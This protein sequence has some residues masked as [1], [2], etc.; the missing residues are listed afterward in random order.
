VIEIDELESYDNEERQRDA[1]DEETKK[2]K[3]RL[4]GP[5]GKIHNIVVNIRGST[6]RAAEFVELA[7]RLI[8]LDNRTRWNS[9]FLM[10]LIALNHRGAI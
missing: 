8:P 6:A 1:G 9:W 7:G 10:L 3:F 4:I 2:T 5:L